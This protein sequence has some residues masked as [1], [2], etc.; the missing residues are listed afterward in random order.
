MLRNTKQS[1]REELIALVHNFPEV[2]TIGRSGVDI[3]PLQVGVGLEQVQ[4]FGKYLG[5]SPTNVAVA[6]AKYGH[7]A[8]TI[9]GVGADPFGNFVRLEMRRLGVSDAYVK[10]VPEFLTPVT[11]CEIFPPDHFPIYFYRKPTAPDLQLTA[12]DIPCEALRAAEAFCFSGT[13]LS[14]EPSRSAHRK[15]LET[16]GRQGWTIID[17][18]YRAQF[19]ENE[20][21]ASREIGGAIE[22]ANVAVG[23]REECRVAVGEENPDRAADALLERGVEIAIV[24]QGPLGTLVK[25]ADER[26]EVPVTKVQALNGLGSGDAFGGGLIHGLLRG[27]SIAETIQFASTAGAIVA[28]RLECSTAMPSENEVKQMISIHPDTTPIVEARR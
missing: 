24:K 4:S 17:L 13:G 6:A 18:D 9:T 15:A 5:G 11:F 1:L 12:D 10:V 19:W 16:R 27:W 23:N 7:S 14:E 8:A 26:I 2:L 21:M 20:E 28:T 22:F 25:T 3:Y